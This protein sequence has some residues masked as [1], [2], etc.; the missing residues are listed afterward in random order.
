M[1]GLTI[2]EVYN[3]FFNIIEE[4]NKFELYT[5]PD[6]K[7]GGISYENRRN[8]IEKKL[9]NPDITHTDL[10]D[11]TIGPII[12]EEYKE[13]VSKRMNIEAYM[14]LKAGYTDSIK[15]LKNILELKFIWLKTIL[16]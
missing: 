12:N 5:N 14:K 13:E 16:D 6:S 3:S 10:Q 7:R 1:I 2:L 15:I 4:K 9:G 11:E 8:E